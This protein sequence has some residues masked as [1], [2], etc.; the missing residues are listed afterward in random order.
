MGKLITILIII[1]GDK[2]RDEEL[3]D[4]QKVLNDSGIKTVIASTSIQPVTGMLG[5]KAQPEVLV[6]QVRPEQYDGVVF[7]GG[8]GASVYFKDPQAHKIAK[9]F[10]ER[11]K[12]TAA[13]CIA[14]RTLAE[15]GLLKGKQFTA[16]QSE[17]LA[18][19]KLGGLPSERSVVKDDNIITANGPKAAKEFAKAI[20]EYAK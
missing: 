12:V 17:V 10:A 20:A 16:W 15:A 9:N 14:P 8:T 3:F 11:G 5:G 6:S 4:T 19:S 7:V 18:I 13:I 1:A 2:F